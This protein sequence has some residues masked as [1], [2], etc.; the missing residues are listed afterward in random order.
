[1]LECV[2]GRGDIVAN[3]SP[4]TDRQYGQVLGVG[5]GIGSEGVGKLWVRVRAWV[6]NVRR[7]MLYVRGIQHP[8]HVW[9][10]ECV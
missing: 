8:T 5:V 9:G 6:L 3:E 10:V 1:M 2:K 4:V 7:G